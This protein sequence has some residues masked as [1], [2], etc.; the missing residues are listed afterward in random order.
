V[1]VGGCPL[2]AF[3][4]P[5]CNC[6]LL[7]KHA[8]QLLSS[9]SNGSRRRSFRDRHWGR[10]LLCYS[11]PIRANLSG[12]HKIC[13]SSSLAIRYINLDHTHHEESI[14]MA[15]KNHV[16]KI[17]L[18]FGIYHKLKHVSQ[19]KQKNNVKQSSQ[20]HTSRLQFIRP[21]QFQARI[22]QYY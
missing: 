21:L 3:L 9:S 2:S 11:R 12:F 19:V 1:V 20:T 17:L 5:I 8:N 6:L 10:R 18:H 22:I 13:E 16:L 14:F 7:S 15:G 4:L